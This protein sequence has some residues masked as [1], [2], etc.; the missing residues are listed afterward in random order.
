MSVRANHL[1]AALIVPAAML[2]C[3]SDA[4]EPSVT[5]PAPLTASVGSFHA[6]AI[7]STGQPYCWGRNS[8]G[9][10]GNPGVVGDTSLPVQTADAPRLVSVAASF[11]RDLL[12]LPLSCGLTVAGE[13]Y[14]WGGD[15]DEQLGPPDPLPCP[16]FPGSSVETPGPCRSL[17]TRVAPNQAFRQLSVGGASL[18]GISTA[19]RLFCWGNGRFGKL[20]RGSTTPSAEPVAILPDHEFVM[21]AVGESHVCGL[22]RLGALYCWGANGLGQIGDG[23]TVTRLTPTLVVGGYRF[24]AVTVGGDH[25]CAIRMDESLACWGRNDSGQLGLGQDS[26]PPALGA[27]LVPETVAGGHRFALV[28]AGNEYTCA[29]R[30]DQEMYCWGL[31]GALGIAAAHDLVLQ[32]T[33]VDGGHR[34]ESVSASTMVTCGLATSGQLLCWGNGYSGL[35]GHG[36]REL[37]HSPVEVDLP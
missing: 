26:P 14:C 2:G 13:A 33:P 23:T 27:R 7:S 8:Y 6:C 28:A 5:P 36:L 19:F 37:V 20:G 11:Q 15:A 1:I 12:L 17:P 24:K 3:T 25:T 4:T 31:P 34:F 30:I 18:C 22:T 35:V 29:I 10:V 16:G 32:P 21:V 9:Q